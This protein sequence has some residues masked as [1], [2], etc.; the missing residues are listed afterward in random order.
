MIKFDLNCS[1][2]TI[3][4]DYKSH[5][6]KNLIENFINF[7]RLF[8]KQ[9][10]D[11]AK[12]VKLKENLFVL[13]WNFEFYLFKQYDKYDYLSEITGLNKNEFKQNL[14]SELKF[15]LSLS[16]NRSSITLWLQYAILKFYLSNQ[17][18]LKEIRKIFEMLFKL[19]SL[20]RETTLNLCLTYVELEFGVFKRIFN[21]KQKYVDDSVINFE[22]ANF[23]YNDYFMKLI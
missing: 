18:G 13:K 6:N 5:K 10:I 3:F 9:A 8:L 19:P 2:N 11:L 16:E 22:L 1:T 21:L 15:D 23:D 14:I 4:D 12:T 17:E 7:N 20:D